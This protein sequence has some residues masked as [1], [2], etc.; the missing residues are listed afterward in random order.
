MENNL[1]ETF[2]GTPLYA[3]PE[4]LKGEPYDFKHDL[5]AIGVLAYELFYGRLPFDIHKGDDLFKIVRE[6]IQFPTEFG[7]PT[8]YFKD[9]VSTTL[10]KD[11]RSRMDC[12]QMLR[13]PLITKYRDA[14]T[15]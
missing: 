1:R 4:L 15:C 14:E 5:W 13:H 7:S 12:D 9:F 2:C 10:S 11:P 8:A 3:S 6:D